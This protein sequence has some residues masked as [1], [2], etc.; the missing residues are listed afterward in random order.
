MLSLA[1]R[2]PLSRTGPRPAATPAEE[3]LEALIAPD[4]RDCARNSGAD[5]FRGRPLGRSFE[6]GSVRPAR[7]QDRGLATP[8]VRHLP[9]GIRPAV[10]RASACDGADDQS[11][12]S[13]RS[14][15]A[16]RPGRRQQATGGEYPAGHR[17][18]RRRNTAVRGGDD[19]GG[20]GGRGRG[21]GGTHGR[22]SAVA[23]TGRSRQPAR[24]ADGAA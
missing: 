1:E 9:A 23:R 13:T 7:G 16:D 18:A 3:R 19:E 24:L 5:D 14:D 8:A 11:A 17:R 22:F 20:A 21:R 2:R 12:R 10:G 6:P 15:G 4:R